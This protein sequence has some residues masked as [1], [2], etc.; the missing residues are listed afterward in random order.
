MRLLGD[1]G[2]LRH[3]RAQP[4]AYLGFRL[5]LLL[6]LLLLMLLDFLVDLHPMRQ[7]LEISI[8]REQLRLSLLLR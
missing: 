3:R 4:V 2:D 1:L 7:V 6:L 5:K 8:A